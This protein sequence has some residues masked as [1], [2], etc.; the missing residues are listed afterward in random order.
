[1]G[2]SGCG[3]EG[4]VFIELLGFDAVT[5]GGKRSTT[6]VH[7]PS[8]SD[9]GNADAEGNV[10]PRSWMDGRRRSKSESARNGIVVER[11]SETLEGF[12]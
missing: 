8:G 11:K 4:I 5:G 1:M 3:G 6:N 9:G 12:L 7:F 10:K 2:V